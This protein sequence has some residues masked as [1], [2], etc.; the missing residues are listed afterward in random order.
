MNRIHAAVIL[1]VLLAAFA[2]F[3]H[4]A[5]QD[6]ADTLEEGLRTLTAQVDAQA[7]ADARAQAARLQRLCDEKE[8]LLTLFVKRDLVNTLC[9]C[10]QGLDAYL[11]EDYRGDALLEIARARAQIAA[12]RRQYFDFA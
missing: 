4:L 2:V 11:C 10:L 3:G 7:Y 9:I 12:L 6:T 1:L 8:G 5:V